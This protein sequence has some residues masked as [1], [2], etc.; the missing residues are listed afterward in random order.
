LSILLAAI[1]DTTD[2]QSDSTTAGIVG[3]LLVNRHYASPDDLKLVPTQVDRSAYNALIYKK[4]LESLEESRIV[5]A[6]RFFC[7]KLHAVDGDG[8]EIVPAQVL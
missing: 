5:Q 3:D 8:V 7:K 4:K 1:R 2:K 6:Y